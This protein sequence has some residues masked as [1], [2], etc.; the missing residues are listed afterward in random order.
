[1]ETGTTLRP[2]PSFRNLIKWMKLPSF[3][4]AMAIAGNFT[5]LV[6]HFKTFGT[7][8]FFCFQSRY[9]EI[10]DNSKISLQFSTMV[11]ERQF[12]IKMCI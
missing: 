2:L 7:F 8:F 3:S 10:I 5:L 1:M 4:S 6:Q 9:H 12:L 11:E